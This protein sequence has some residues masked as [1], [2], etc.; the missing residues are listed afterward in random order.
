MNSRLDRISSWLD[1]HPLVRLGVW[2]AAGLVAVATFAMVLDLVAPANQGDE[3][4]KP[5]FVEV[6]FPTMTC[7]IDT[8]EQDIEDCVAK[9]E[10]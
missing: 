2:A 9:E 5:R 3:D 1:H 4:E 10:R 7:V 8:W 6:E